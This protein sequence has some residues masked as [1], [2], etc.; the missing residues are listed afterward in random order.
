MTY[1]TVSLKHQSYQWILLP[2]L[3]AMF[4]NVFE[5]LFYSMLFWQSYL[6][7]KVLRTE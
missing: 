3:I 4:T 2:W 5:Y 7:K 6:M 1:L